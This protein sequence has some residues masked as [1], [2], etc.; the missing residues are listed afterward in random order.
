M[1][2]P[3]NGLTHG[4]DSMIK[5]FLPLPASPFPLPLVPPLLL[6]LLS[7]P[8]SH[9][10]AIL[11]LLL[12][13]CFPSVKRS[14]KSELLP[15]DGR[16]VQ[17]LKM[18]RTFLTQLWVGSCTVGKAEPWQTAL[19]YEVWPS[20]IETEF[21]TNQWRGV[22]SWPLPLEL[23]PQGGEGGWGWKGVG[24]GVPCKLIVLASG[25]NYFCNFPDTSPCRHPNVNVITLLTFWRDC[26]LKMFSV[27]LR[28]TVICAWG[29]PLPGLQP[30]WG[31]GA[32][33]TP[34]SPSPCA[35]SRLPKR[36]LET[37]FAEF[38][39]HSQNTLLQSSSVASLCPLWVDVT[40]EK[41]INSF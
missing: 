29:P 40:I 8:P 37:V 34:V 23:Y 11:L 12:L 39:R 35:V 19:L 30:P 14:L 16:K 38:L 9:P 33:L 3:L 4:I 32:L 5:C 17:S 25:S 41:Y 6:L 27:L 26:L 10:L 15:R 20:S 22:S 21:L 18:M 28:F 36:W 7:A 31:Q 13:L 1:E 2:S 24:V